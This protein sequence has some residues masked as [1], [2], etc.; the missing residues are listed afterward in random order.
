LADVGADLARAE[1]LVGPL[2]WP[3]LEF[4]QLPGDRDPPLESPQLILLSREIGPYLSRRHVVAHE[5]AHQW[6]G[7]WVTP[8]RWRDVWLSEGIATFL[9]RELAAHF[10]PGGPAAVVRYAN[11]ERVKLKRVV[12][13]L[14]LAGNAKVACLCC[15]KLGKEDPDKVLDESDYCVPY[16]KGFLLL[17]RLNQLVGR[18]AFWFF[19]RQYLATF[20]GGNASSEDFVELWKA[21]FPQVRVDWRG[22]LHRSSLP[23]T[24]Q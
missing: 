16:E 23:D 9:E 14:R 22:W 1:G 17:K 4:L 2:P 8:A 19:L 20:G 6:F 5:L 18:K 21:E 12:S 3:S 24:C 7:N 13:K 15:D 10:V 11:K